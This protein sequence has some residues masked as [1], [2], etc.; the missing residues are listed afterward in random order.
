MTTV[1]KSLDAVTLFVEDT[2][3]SK[4]FYAKA[5]GLPVLFEDQNSVVFRFDHVVI[6]LL[7]VAAAVDLIKPAE[8][9]GSKT[10]A[11]VQFTIEVSDVDSLCSE[12]GQRGVELLNGPMNRPWGVRTASFMDPDGHIWEIAQGLA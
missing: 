7:N 12:L 3:R 8:V 4:A 11:R 5:F 6:N 9:G 2:Q 1:L 10:G